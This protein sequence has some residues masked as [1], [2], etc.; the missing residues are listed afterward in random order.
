LRRFLIG[1]VG[2]AFATLFIS[3]L[4]VFFVVRLIPGDP[5]GVLL[6]RSYSPEIAA[7]LRA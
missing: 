4:I 6:E 3:T 1:R 5:V 7:S 2:G